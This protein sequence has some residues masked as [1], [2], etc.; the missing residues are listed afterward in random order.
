VK[1][2]LSPCPLDDG[3]ERDHESVVQR[4]LYGGDLSIAFSGFAA[5]DAQAGIRAIQDYVR[6]IVI[7]RLHGQDGA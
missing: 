6:R 2:R 5:L 1:S 7:R 3:R 4:R